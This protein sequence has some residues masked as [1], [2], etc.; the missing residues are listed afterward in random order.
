MLFL[1]QL[2]FAFA[3]GWQDI[4]RLLKVKLNLPLNTFGITSRSIIYQ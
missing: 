4:N 1:F 2:I 3:N